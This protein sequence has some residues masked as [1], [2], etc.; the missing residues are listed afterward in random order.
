MDGTTLERLKE[1]A[2]TAKNSAPPVQ[3]LP[4]NHF[5]CPILKDVMDEPCVAADGYTYDRKAIEKWLEEND[6]SPM[7]NLPLPNKDV[8]LNYTLLSAIMEWKTRKQ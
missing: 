3:C 1:V 5:I 7:T 6:N 2:D 8:I 4:P